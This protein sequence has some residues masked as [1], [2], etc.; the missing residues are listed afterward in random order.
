MQTAK[1]FAKM[2]FVAE[3]TKAQLCLSSGR[4]SLCYSLH[5][6]EMDSLNIK[7]AQPYILLTHL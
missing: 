1:T 5:Q 4:A 3:L 6:D 7:T 2:S